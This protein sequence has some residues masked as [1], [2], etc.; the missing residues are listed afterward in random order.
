MEIL[1]TTKRPL[2][3]ARL[4]PTDIDVVHV[5]QSARLRFS[6]LNT[7]Y[8]PEIEAIVQQVS[9]D[10][11][12]AQATQQPY[13]RALLTI[14]DELPASI[15]EE[16]LHPGMPVETFISTED[17]TFFSYLMRPL[18]DSMRHAFVED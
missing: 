12:I 17:R 11:L 10:R 18:L 8:T 1:P 4:K 14:T 3:E 7:R 13:Y 2:V 16:Q 6:A 15:P 5:G 9:A